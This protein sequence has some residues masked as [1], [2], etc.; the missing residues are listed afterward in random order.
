MKFYDRYISGEDGRSVYS[1]IYDLGQEA[2]SAKYFDDIQSV[3][4]ETFS[5]VAFNLKIIF[6]ELNDIGYAFKTEFQFN[7]ERPLLKPLS[8]TDELL[9]K[10]DEA[11]AD[12]GHIP[13]SLK[14]FYKIVGA[15]NFGWDYEREPKMF[16]NCA[17]PIQICSLDGVVSE[18]LNNDWKDYLNEVLEDDTSQFPY[19]ELAADYLHK[20]NISGGLPYAIQITKEQTID[21]LFLNEPN[22]TTFI[23]YLRICMENCGFSRITEPKHNNEYQ[24]FFAKVKPKL[25]M[26]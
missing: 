14:I 24:E 13:H 8:N 23:D 21:S 10:L 16:W 7:F 18:V 25:K 5:R 26:I 20:D 4:V 19:L 1:D 22:E 12:F 11:V 2:F 6:E 15:C 3:L 9:I 17:D